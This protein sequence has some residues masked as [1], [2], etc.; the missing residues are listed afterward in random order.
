VFI[1]LGMAGFFAAAAKTPFSTL[2]IVCEMTGDYQ[3]ILP[4]LWVCTLA[5]LLSDEQ[6]LYRSQVARRSLSP[7][8]QGSYAREVLAGLRVGQFLTPDTPVP[9]L[10]PSDTLATIID[11]LAQSPYTVLP[12]VDANRRLL[13]VVN[14]EEVHQASLAADLRPLLVA[15]D[16]MRPVDNPLL[17]DDRLN[18]AL[19]AF[20]ENDLLALPV[21]EKDGGRLLGIIPRSVV[22]QA[23]LT[24]IHGDKDSVS[25]STLLLGPDLRP[26]ERE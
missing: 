25:E 10:S 14:L 6:S 18:E 19:E 23:Y 12:V 15:E 11:R 17:P 4:A 9:S 22:T 21:V 13:G 2:I 7:A 1:I 26:H 8:H 24:R 20:V 5:Y 16:L 3:M